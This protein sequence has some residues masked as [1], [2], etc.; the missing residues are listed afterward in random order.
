LENADWNF[1][2]VPE[3]MDGMNVADFLDPDIEAKLD[4]L[5]LEEAE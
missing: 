4:K 2:K 3:F 5:E 1:D